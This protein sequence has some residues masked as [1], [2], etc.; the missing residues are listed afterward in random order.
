MIDPDEAYADRVAATFSKL[1]DLANEVTNHPVDLLNHSLRQYFGFSSDFNRGYRT[2]SNKN[3][4]FDN[5]DRRGHDLAERTVTSSRGLTDHN[6][7][8]ID[9]SL[10]AVNSSR[11]FGRLVQGYKIFV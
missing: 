8:K 4:F 10:V 7:S 9:Y 1:F 2:T 6:V 5:G 11:E 3:S